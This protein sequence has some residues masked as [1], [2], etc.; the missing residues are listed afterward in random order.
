MQF[1]IPGATTVVCFAFIYAFGLNVA[2][3]QLVNLLLTPLELALVVPYM[4][5]GNYLLGADVDLSNAS[6]LLTSDLLAALSLLGASVMRGVFA[7]ALLAAPL[8]L[9]LYVVLKPLVRFALH[10]TQT[11]TDKTR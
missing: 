11:D 10:A 8:A 4:A 9:V 1:P 7:W 6:A 5:L 3:T 2:A